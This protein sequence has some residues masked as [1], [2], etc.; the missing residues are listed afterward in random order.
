MS[1]RASEQAEEGIPAR[2][3]PFTWRVLVVE[4]DM[5]QAD[6]VHHQLRRHGHRVDQVE[7]GHAALRLASGADLVLLDLELP[8]M[9]GLEV[10][11]GIRTAHSTPLIAI[12]SHDSEL[13]CVLSLRAGADDCLVRPYRI[14]ELMARMEAIMRRARPR[15]TRRVIEHGPLSI[16]AE[17]REV[18]LAGRRIDMTRKEFDLLRALASRSGV[19]LARD[20]L[21]GQVWG[22]SWSRRTIDTHISSLRNKLG[23]SDWI[24]TVRGV[25][26]RLGQ[27]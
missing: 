25:G 26:F 20:D 1:S 8:D 18:R 27:G 17:S 4:S 9:D 19:V 7:T 5:G 16:D 22:D 2:D 24:V 6:Y 11:R 10:C 3:S 12:S 14:R 15:P 23:S 21:M 13:D